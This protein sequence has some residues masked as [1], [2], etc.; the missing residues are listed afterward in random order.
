MNVLDIII[1]AMVAS[2]LFRGFEIGLVK[3]LFSTVGFIGGLFLGAWLEQYTVTLADTPIER[4]VVTIATTL[5]CALILLAVGEWIGGKLKQRVAATIHLNKFDGYL[6]SLLGAA[7]LAVS[8]WLAAAILVTLPSAGVQEQI[9][10]SRIISAMN[11]TL[12]PA[13]DIIARIGK[14]IEPNGFPRVFTDNEPALSG[15]TEVPGIGPELQQAIDRAKLSTVKIEGLGCGG[16]VDGSGFV[17]GTDLVVTNAHVVAGVSRPY[18]KDANGQHSATA[19]WF[20][21]DL[22]FAILR[23]QNLAGQPLTINNS[24][25]PRGTKAAVLGYPGGGALT[26]GGAEVLDEFTA[27]GRDIYGQ[28][29]T[30]RDVYSLAAKVIPGNSGGPVVAADGTVIGVIFAQSTSYENVGYA[31]ST[32]QITAAISQAQAQNRAVSTGNCAKE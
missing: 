12:P 29:I 26:A 17:I 7:T 9:R 13:P 32:P 31:L 2:S 22:D 23:T 28:G 30:E 21:P 11:R 10:G 18:I 15:D 1:I 25:V 14:L 16:I 4:S 8:V 27:R 20:D 19:I 5:G 6:G 3:Q 24:I